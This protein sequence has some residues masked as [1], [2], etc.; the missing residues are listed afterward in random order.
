MF[1]D[2]MH[3]A[4]LIDA[5]KVM[6]SHVLSVDVIVFSS[7]FN[8]LLIGNCRFCSHG[9]DGGKNVM[10]AATVSV[11]GGGEDG[12][13]ERGGLSAGCRVDFHAED[14]GVNLHENWIFEGDAAACNDVVDWNA[15]F[16][17][18]VDDLSCAK[19]GSFDERA[20]DVFRPCGERHADDESGQ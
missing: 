5:E 14:I 11:R 17:E 6:Q 4:F 1:A 15:M 7:I 9:A 16:S 20:V 2:V 19:S 18:I 13:A 3:K 10:V 8:D 12:R